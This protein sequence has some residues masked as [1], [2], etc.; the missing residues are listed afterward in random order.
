[1]GEE[2]RRTCSLTLS[3]LP[4][5]WKP[6]TLTLRAPHLPQHPMLCEPRDTRPLAHEVG[7]LA[8][9]SCDGLNTKV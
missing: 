1:V 6:P 4:R 8:T 2:V 7:A 5:I 3:F 9:R